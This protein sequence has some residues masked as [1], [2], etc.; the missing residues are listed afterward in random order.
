[1][2]YQTMRLLAIS[3]TLCGREV[4][5]EHEIRGSNSSLV[6]GSGNPILGFQFPLQ[7]EHPGICEGGCEG[8]NTAQMAGNIFIYPL[9][10]LLADVLLKSRKGPPLVPAHVL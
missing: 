4:L 9:R 3:V 1:M 5:E 2:V 8:A 7:R 6:L 10:K